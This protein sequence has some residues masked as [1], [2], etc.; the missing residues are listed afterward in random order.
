M[1]SLQCIPCGK[2]REEHGHTMIVSACCALVPRI[3][4]NKSVQLPYG[5]NYHYLSPMTLRPIS[6]EVVA[7]ACS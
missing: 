2:N 7:A 5:I 6:G 4:N 3:H 1:Y